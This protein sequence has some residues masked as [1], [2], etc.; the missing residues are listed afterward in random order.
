MLNKPTYRITIEELRQ[1]PEFA[2]LDDILAQKMILTIQEFCVILANQ[3]NH[4][5]SESEMKN[6][7]D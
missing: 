5:E 6:P 3:Y 2:H 7:S 4:L 1:C